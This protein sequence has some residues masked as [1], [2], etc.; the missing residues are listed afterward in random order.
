MVIQSIW[1]AIAFPL[2]GTLANGLLGRRLGR[3]F[4]SVVGPAVIGLAFVVGL[5]SALDL[6]AFPVHDRAVV[7]TLWDWITIP[8][9]GSMGGTLQVGVSLL[10]DPLSVLMVLVVTGVGFL[11]H[12]YSIGYMQHEDD[13]LYARFFTFLNLFITSM[14]ILVLADNYLLMYVG[15]ELVG[16]CSY[17]LIGFW[18]HR[19]DEPQAP[20]YLKDGEKVAVPA[21]LNPA[22]SGK[23]AFIVNRVGD[24][25]FALGV[26]LIWSTFGTLNFADVFGAAPQVASGTLTAI[27]LLLFVGAVGKSAQLPLYVWLPDAMAGPTPVSALIHAATMVTAGIYMIARSHVFYALAPT[28]SLVVAVVGA[29]TALYAATIALVQTDLKRILAYS[30][31]SQLGYMFLAVGVGAYSSGMFHLTTHAFFKALLFLAAGSVMH[32]LGDVID[33][34]RMGGLRQKMPRTYWTFVVGALALAG[35]PLT[36]GFF[37]KDE[38]L[39]QAFEFSPVLWAAGLLTALLTAFYTFR[40]LFV[41]FWG[42]PRDQELFDHAHE[43]RGVMTWPLI[44]LALLALFGGLLGLPR[45]LGIDHALDG[46]LQ[47]VFVALGGEGEV[48]HGLSVGLEW[49]LL[50]VSSLIALGGI[51]LAYWF[52]VLNAEVPATLALRFKSVFKL[53]VNK[54]YV[55]ELYDAVFVEPGKALARFLAQGIDKT[56]IDGA[57][58]GGARLIA[59]GGA[60]LGR[61]QSGYIRNYALAMF[62]GVIVLVSYFFLR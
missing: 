52:Y 4:V 42:R 2:V 60:L 56:V 18:F 35:F 44:L 20:I 14:L 40:A 57:I 62:L 51:V 29:A 27:T 37:S 23:K 22:D 43:S 25:G 34:R 26:F 31:I 53:L 5:F 3:G 33:I 55:D 13:R 9:R 58:D 59:E 8:Q 21:N 46:W 17:L 24:F 30:T 47:P 50:G 54:Y 28:S 16:L 32:A 1:L 49:G 15:W 41:A 19:A 39:A 48:A 6:A 7:V 36:S 45:I 38:I 10:A 11:I 12:V 61:L